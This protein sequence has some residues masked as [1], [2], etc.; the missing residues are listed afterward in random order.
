MPQ[1]RSKNRTSD[2]VL[3]FHVEPLEDR[4]PL[5]G[6]VSVRVTGNSITI[7][8]SN[9]ADEIRV[10]YS[11][12][13]LSL[14]VS[15][16]LG[17][18]TT[19]NGQTEFATYLNN[20]DRLTVKMR[21]GD[22]RVSFQSIDIAGTTRIS[23]G[24][25]DTENTLAFNSNVDFDKLM[26]KGGADADVVTFGSTTIHSRLKANMGGGNDYVLFSQAV[27]LGGST[28]VR[29]GGG[30]DHTRILFDWMESSDS[31]R[32]S[33]NGGQ[34]LLNV[35]GGAFENS[36]DFAGSFETINVIEGP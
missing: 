22:D 3:A 2:S 15:S 6:D 31:I 30:D 33:G 34:D 18:D 17:S 4:L 12:A 27:T 32:L 13:N 25:A 21:G 9:E 36:I 1:R 16:V 20:P 19:V 11:T 23:L 14:T 28:N 8:G 29:M 26:I 10:A 35:N 7:T 5:A 24:S